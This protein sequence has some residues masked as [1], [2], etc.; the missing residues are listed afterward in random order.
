MRRTAIIALVALLF[1]LVAAQPAAQRASAEDSAA[2][3]AIKDFEFQPKEL[4]VKTGATV[5]WTN[6]GSSSHTV[7]SDDGSFESPTLAKGKTYRR[8]FDKPGTYPYYCALHGGAGGDGM[9]G[10]IVVTP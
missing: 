9:S 2:S 8:K 5:T 3:V 1:G 6:D 4:K 7:T 10:A